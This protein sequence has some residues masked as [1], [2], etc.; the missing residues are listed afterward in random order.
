MSHTP[1]RSSPF[2]YEEIASKLANI[3][4]DTFPL[5]RPFHIHSYNHNTNTIASL[6]TLVTQ[7]QNTAPCSST[8]AANTAAEQKEREIYKAIMEDMK[9]LTYK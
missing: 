9:I 2:Y 4:P 8:G 7:T 5:F 1:A 6:A 3:T